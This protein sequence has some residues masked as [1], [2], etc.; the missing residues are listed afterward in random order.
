MSLP[1][2]VAGAAGLALL[3]IAASPA[4]A[5]PHDRCAYMHHESK[6]YKACMAEEAAAKQKSEPAPP[7]VPEP[8][9]AP[10]PKS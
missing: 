9:P 7:P 5:D 4:A 1:A 2:C 8:K 10:R 6:A 3:A